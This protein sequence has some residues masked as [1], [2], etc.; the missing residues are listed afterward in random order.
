MLAPLGLDDVE[1]LIADALHCEPSSAGTLTLVVHEKT[2]G[3]PFFAIQFITELE[4]E[5]LLRLDG[6]AGAWTWDLDRIRGKRYSGNVVDLM[7]G[8]LSRFP[9]ATQESLKQLAC[10]GDSAAFELLRAVYEDSKEDMH[11]RLWEAVRAGLIFRTE[12]SY[13]FLHDRVQEAAYSLI[14]GHERA[15][16]HLRIG[17]ILMKTTPEERLEEAIFEIVN[18]LNRGSHLITDTG[19]RGRAANLN[20]IA[21]KRAKTSTAYASALKYLHGRPLATKRGG[22]GE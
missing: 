15:Q 19:E 5:G 3:N 22:L 11:H 14:P 7:V 16:T 20:L 2:G 13:R 18:Q 9:K 17:R 6:D 8:K 12:N 4:E 21:G 10:L 1:R